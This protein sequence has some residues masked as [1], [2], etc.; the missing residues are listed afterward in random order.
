VWTATRRFVAL[1]HDFGVRC[2]DRRLTDQIDWAFADLATT[3][4][5]QSWYSI[6]G[7]EAS[8]LYRVDWEGELVSD[9]IGPGKA[10]AWFQW[11][12]NRRASAS[13]GGIA[14]HAG[15]VQAAAGAIIIPGRSGAGKS[16]I[17]ALLTRLG[18][19]YLTDEAVVFDDA[20]PLI[21][22]YPKPL[23]LGPDSIE[24]LGLAADLPEPFADADDDKQLVPARL[25]R[26]H[27]IASSCEPLGVVLFERAAG[28]EPMGDPVSKG[29]LL[30]AL[31]GDA[32]SFP[33]RP[34]ATLDALADVAM[35]VPGIRV[36][37]RGSREIA[38]LIAER[39]L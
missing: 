19:G 24:L 9:G 29:A 5:P 15:A 2:E 12:A 20:E 38:S 22:P 8:P 32:L 27:C 18:F 4:E 23:S 25:L 30:A 36:K 35:H 10:L 13:V 1:R 6:S 34:R 17:V 28:V 16:T 21:E 26:D 33:S 11:D 39:F 31:A 7:S 14:L 3:G 37:A